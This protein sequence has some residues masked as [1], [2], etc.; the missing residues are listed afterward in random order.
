V[1]P[2][3]NLL[4]D[5]MHTKKKKKDTYTETSFDFFKEV[6]LEVNAEI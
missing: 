3:V 1:C 2:G 4:A 5:N 6:D